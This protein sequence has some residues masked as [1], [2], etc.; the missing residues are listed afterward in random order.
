MLQNFKKYLL[1]FFVKK[2]FTYIIKFRNG[3]KTYVPYAIRFSLIRLCVHHSVHHP[4]RVSRCLRLCRPRRLHRP[5]RRP[6]PRP[7]LSPRRLLSTR[8]NLIKTILNESNRF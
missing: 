3:L 6:R 5:A 8:P 4:C 1:F 7:R 2:S